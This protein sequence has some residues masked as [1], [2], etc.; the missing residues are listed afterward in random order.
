MGNGHH[1]P[2]PV[3]LN[4]TL[5]VVSGL[6]DAGLI[7]GYNSETGERQWSQSTQ[8][9]MNSNHQLPSNDSV[10]IVPSESGLSA[11]SAT[12]E[13][14]WSDDIRLSGDIMGTD[15]LF[16]IPKYNGVEARSFDG[17]QQWTWESD[18]SIYSL[19]GDS[20]TLF[21]KSGTSLY[22]LD[23]IDGTV[24]WTFRTRMEPSTPPIVKNGLLIVG[25]EDGQLT[26]LY[27]DTH[28]EAWSIDLDS[29]ISTPITVGESNIYAAGWS[30]PLHAINPEDGSI[31]WTFDPSYQTVSPVSE[32]DGTAYMSS[33][34]G[35]L[36]AR[37]SDDGRPK[38]S[39][40]MGSAS[41]APPLLREEQIYATSDDGG[42]Y[43]LIQPD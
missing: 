26:A 21:T 39:F 3:I 41:W 22:A 17:S 18:S 13:V 25:R 2:S 35:V 14:M 7:E 31:N 43:N 19:G 15:E 16:Y 24:K 23:A 5:V 6:N 32:T 29:S 1:F 11:V 33:D 10:V 30:Y 27:E 37:N 28:E 40:E 12:G 38:W 8:T 34:M 9:S 20:N 36:F 4:D 42:I